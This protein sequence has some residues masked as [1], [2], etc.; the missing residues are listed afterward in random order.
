MG[1]RPQKRKRPPQGLVDAST[2]KGA[3]R[4]GQMLT[5]R[6]TPGEHDA[7]RAAARRLELSIA[8]YLIGLHEQAWQQMQKG[9]V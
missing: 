3:E 5:L 1:R 8:D 2:V 7:I 6:V 9:K 4:R